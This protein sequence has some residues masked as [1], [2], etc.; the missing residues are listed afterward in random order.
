MKHYYMLG[1]A[2]AGLF[3][4]PSY[5]Q[6]G[7][8]QFPKPFTPATAFAAP[9]WAPET[10]SLVPSAIDDKSKGVTIYAAE[11][12]DASKKRSLIKFKSKNPANFETI[13]YYQY[14]DEVG[15]Q[16]YGLTCGAS[17][18]KYYY[19][20]FAYDY[21]F[22]QMVKHFSRIDLETGDTLHIRSFTEDEQKAWYGNGY[23]G[24]LRNALYDMA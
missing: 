12:M 8:H 11:R 17:D 1:L 18:G 19:G 2:M 23:G 5:G 22:S 16:M 15:S 4:L 3:C 6:G 10:P 13:R 21:T 7:V 14:N 24:T 20:F 9:A